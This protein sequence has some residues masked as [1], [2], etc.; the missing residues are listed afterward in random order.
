MISALKADYNITID[1]TATKYIGLTIKWD[2]ENWKVQTSMP[3]YLSKVFL[4]FKYEIPYKNQNSP[5]PHVIPN[6]G[7]KAPFTEPEEEPPLS[8]KKKLNLS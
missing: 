1:G 6:Y 7:A 5:H 3:G 8:E 4:R 2:L